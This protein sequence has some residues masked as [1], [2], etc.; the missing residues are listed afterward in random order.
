MRE[1]DKLVEGFYRQRYASLDA[2]A[3]AAFR[4]LLDEDDPDLFAWLTAREPPPDHYRPLI[5]AMREAGAS[6]A[7]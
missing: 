2:D 1:L 3:Q 4:A 6:G 7:V 5:D